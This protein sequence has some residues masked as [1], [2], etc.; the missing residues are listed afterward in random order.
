[1]NIYI[2][3]SEVSNI[4]EHEYVIVM[5][6]DAMLQKLMSDNFLSQEERSA[7]FLFPLFILSHICFICESSFSE[8]ELRP[9]TS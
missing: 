3:E 7:I 2:S 6:Q 5:F 9:Y 1:M 4:I 8:Q